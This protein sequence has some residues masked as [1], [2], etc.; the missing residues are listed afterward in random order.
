MFKRAMMTGLMLLTTSSQAGVYKCVDEKGKVHY[1]DKVCTD[2]KKPIQFNDSARNVTSVDS[3][4]TRRESAGY[5][6]RLAQDR[7]TTLAAQR[8]NEQSVEGFH[9]ELAARRKL[10]LQGDAAYNARAVVG[11]HKNSGKTPAEQRVSA[12]TQAAN[13][14]PESSV[15]RTPK[16]VDDVR[17]PSPYTGPR[18]T[19]IKPDYS[20]AGA[21]RDNQ[22]NRFKRDALGRLID[23]E[24]FKVCKQSGNKAVCN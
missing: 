23:R 16:R 7:A 19:K 9:R 5:L 6:E 21:I 3:E 10:S 20:G 2:G 8:D 15:P 11:G 22:G 17:P 1:Q 13:A 14:T 24:T 18:I 12:L 4:V